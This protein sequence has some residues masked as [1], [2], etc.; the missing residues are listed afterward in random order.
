VTL[1]SGSVM[2]LASVAVALALAAVAPADSPPPATTFT[3]G[4][5]LPAA[6]ISGLQRNGNYEPGIAADGAGTFWIGAAPH[7]SRSND[8]RRFGGVV[9]GADIWTSGDGGRTYRWITDPFRILGPGRPEPAGEDTDIAAAPQPNAT[10]HHNVYAV[11]LWGIASS[12]ATS[13]DG[14]RSWLANPLGGRVPLNDRPWVAA[15]GR[16]AVYVVYHQ[17]NLLTE[18]VPVDLPLATDTDAPIVDRYD[19]CDLEGNSTGVALDPV[20]ETVLAL[21]ATSLGSGNTF[22]KPAVDN[23]TDSP[24]RQSLYVPLM[25]CGYTSAAQYAQNG[26]PTN[27][28]VV[29]VAIS[30]DRGRTFIQRR[31]TSFA[32]FIHPV[33]ALNVAVD[34]AG[35]VYLTWFDNHHAFLSV[36]SDG[37]RTWGSPQQV[38]QAP[39]L[40]AAYPTIAAGA[41]GHVAIAWY[42]TDRAGDVNSTRTMGSPGAATSATWAV[43]VA[44]SGDG[45]TTFAQRQATGTIHTGA[46][47]TRGGACEAASRGLFDDFGIAMSPTTGLVSIAYTSDQ[48]GGGATDIH[49][50]Y[51]SEIPG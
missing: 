4:R 48:P 25:S 16:C 36:S 1:R 39:S 7:P 2:T 28:T 41:P 24:F 14:G 37:G 27:R 9:S 23:G 15:D 11:S 18:L 12:L 31:V 43:F 32:P 38:D 21:G 20:N 19:L 10:G 8:A 6:P 51:V 44:K 47:C 34:R 49:A 5:P 42:G 26:C 30:R 17:F 45:G 33:W 35:R 3:E 13:Q 22:G 40:A 29:S 46:V 50:D